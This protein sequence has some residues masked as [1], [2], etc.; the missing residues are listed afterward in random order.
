MNINTVDQKINF[1]NLYEKNITNISIK[2]ESNFK[3]FSY[4]N[5]SHAFYYLIPLKIYNS[6]TITNDCFLKSLYKTI[7][8]KLFDLLIVT[9]SDTEFILDDNYKKYTNII[10]DNFN[11]KYLIT[12]HAAAI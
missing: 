9:T 6:N 5:W 10:L 12:T 4:K 7:D 1:K 11:K 8:E 2:E 3:N